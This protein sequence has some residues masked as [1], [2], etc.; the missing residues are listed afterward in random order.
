MLE[1]EYRRVSLVTKV[2][3]AKRILKDIDPL[4]ISIQA[5]VPFEQIIRELGKWEDELSE[6]ICREM[7]KE[8]NDGIR[9]PND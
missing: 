8:E 7:K 9:K 3:M 2:R 1:E 5:V 6:M 4:D